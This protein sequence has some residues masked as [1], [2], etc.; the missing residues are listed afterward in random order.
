MHFLLFFPV[1]VVWCLSLLWHVVTPFHI[2][3]ALY[4]RVIDM[5]I[6]IIIFLIFFA[7]FYSRTVLS[8][9]HVVA[10]HIRRVWYDMFPS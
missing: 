9:F 1:Y 7:V 10:H 3:T 2:S 4:Q 5:I 6:I 8:Q